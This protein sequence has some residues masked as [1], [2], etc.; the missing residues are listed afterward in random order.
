VTK[1]NLLCVDTAG[2]GSREPCSFSVRIHRIEAVVVVL[3]RPIGRVESFPG[4]VVSIRSRV[5]ECLVCV[6]CAMVE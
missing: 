4:A 6:Q 3:L 5:F 1:T 2:C